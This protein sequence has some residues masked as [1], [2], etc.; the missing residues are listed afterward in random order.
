MGLV[1]A[2]PERSDRRN[3]AVLEL[4]VV[5]DRMIVLCRAGT[6]PPGWPFGRD[7]RGT[8]GSDI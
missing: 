1:E 2:D 4:R 5:H 6:H 3:F 7:V 8:P